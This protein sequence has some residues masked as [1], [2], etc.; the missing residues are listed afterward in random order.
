[1]AAQVR[2]GETFAHTAPK[3]LTGIFPSAWAVRRSTARRFGRK[4]LLAGAPGG[5]NGGRGA[6]IKPPG[7]R[8]GVTCA[9]VRQLT[10]PFWN[11][12][13]FFDFQINPFPPP[14]DQV[15]A[16]KGRGE[17]TTGGPSLVR[18][19]RY[20]SGATRCTRQNR[21][22]RLENGRDEGACALTLRIE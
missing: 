4:W 14:T 12:L 21:K 20:G 5:K 1:M 8:T 16:G 22:P 18:H 15:H 13:I 10:S 9:D 3:S 11:L 7:G 17:R 19:R 6:Q 2:G